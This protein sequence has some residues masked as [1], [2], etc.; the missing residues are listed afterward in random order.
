LED[1]EE[2]DLND[3]VNLPVEELA[4]VEDFPGYEPD[5]NQEYTGENASHMKGSDFDIDKDDFL[6]NI[7]DGE[8]SDESSPFF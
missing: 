8:D 6:F 1:P 7:G 2:E 5:E 3:W 4:R